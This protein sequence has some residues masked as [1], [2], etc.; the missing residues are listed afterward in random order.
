LGAK[1]L[2]NNPLAYINVS[3]AFADN[4]RAFRSSKV[5]CANRGSSFT[6]ILYFDTSMVRRAVAS[7]SKNLEE[8]K[9]RD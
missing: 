5:S 3:A 9:N 6:S 2:E 1:T 8:K 4:T 7:V